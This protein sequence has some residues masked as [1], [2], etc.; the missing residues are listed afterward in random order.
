MNKVYSLI[1]SSV[2][3]LLLKCA[4]VMSH[5]NGRGDL[6]NAIKKQYYLCNFYINVTSLK[7]NY[8]KVKII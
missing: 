2:S 4:M 6:G 3:I 1:S 7:I 8:R 5:G